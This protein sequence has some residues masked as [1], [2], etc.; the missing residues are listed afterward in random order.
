MTGPT[1]QALQKEAQA[2]YPLL[3]IGARA[4]EQGRVLASEPA[5]DLER[6]HR[7]RPRLGMADGDLPA[8]GKARLERCFRLPVDHGYLVTRAR[9]IP[10][11][12]RADDA[13]SENDYS[14]ARLRQRQRR[15]T[16]WICSFDPRGTTEFLRLLYQ[17]GLAQQG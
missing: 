16:L 5:Q 10:G 11:T 9:Q 2:P 8:V 6:G 3:E 1:R 15:S 13:G 17:A 7:I 14:H 4:E 12:G